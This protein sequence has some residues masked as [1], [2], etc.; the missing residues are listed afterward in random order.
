MADLNCP[1][2]QSNFMQIGRLRRGQICIHVKMDKWMRQCMW[3]YSTLFPA[4]AVFNN[5]NIPS[6]CY[7]S[8]KEFDFLVRFLFIVQHW[9]CCSAAVGL[10]RKWAYRKPWIK[11]LL[12]TF[13]F[14][15][16]IC[17]QWKT[18]L[19]KAWEWFPLAYDLLFELLIAG[20]SPICIMMS[21]YC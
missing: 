16:K 13:T 11:I 10:L 3:H 21:Q 1:V 19:S 20:W 17:P 4:A 8:L 15:R 6:L 12:R 14:W 18:W 7:E 2:H 9:G 5:W